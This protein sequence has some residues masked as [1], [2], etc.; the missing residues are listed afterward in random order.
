MLKKRPPSRLAFRIRRQSALLSQD[1]LA[2]EVGVSRQTIN[3]IECGRWSPSLAVALRLARR[4]DTSVEELFTPDD[5]AEV[6]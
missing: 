6:R 3:A 4:L 2:R 5:A 1:E